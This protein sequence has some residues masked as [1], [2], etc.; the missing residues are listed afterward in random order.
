MF[1]LASILI[2]A[3]STIYPSQY[4]CCICHLVTCHAVAVLW[5]VCSFASLYSCVIEMLQMIYTNIRI[6]IYTDVITHTFIHRYIYIYTYR[7]NIPTPRLLNVFCQAEDPW[8]SCTLDAPWWCQTTTTNADDVFEL[9]TQVV[10]PMARDFQGIAC[11]R[12]CSSLAGV[13]KTYFIWSL[14][15]EL[16]TWLDVDLRFLYGMSQ[17][18]Q[19]FWILE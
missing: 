10:P 2:L 17:H 15:C 7:S 8:P 16:V 19:S 18:L 6:Y 9:M 4:H 11:L 14:K 13:E 1:V 12:M 5:Y 3:I